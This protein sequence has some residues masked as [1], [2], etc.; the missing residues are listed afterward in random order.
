MND[1]AI[2]GIRHHGPGSARSVLKALAELR[3]D[4]I[5]V[6]G[7][8]D[9]QGVLPLAADPD[10]KPPVALLLYDPTEPR[11][12]VYYP[13]AE[14][15][16][17]WQAIRHGLQNDIPVRLMDLPQAI[18]LA[19]ESEAE[20]AA[21]PV[22][23]MDE[24]ATSESPAVTLAEENG[25]E[26]TENDTEDSTA[27][28]P[29]LHRDPLRWVAE[30]AGY[31]DGER[32]WE[33]LVE[34]RQDSREL[35]QAIR[36][37]MT[38]LRTEADAQSPSEEEE[39]RREAAMRVQLRVARKE[40]FERIA[41][42]CGAW[43]VPALCDL[44]PAREDNARLKGL[45]KR[46]LAATWV[47][48][49]HGRLT[50]A[51][52]YGAGVE[53]PGFYQHL[54][55]SAG[56]PTSRWLA[57]IAQ[58]L[59]QHD[60]IASTASV[61]EAARLAEALA[62]LRDRPRPTLEELNEAALAVLCHGEA[63]PLRLIEEQL[64]IG[65][66][67]GEVPDR[68]PM[69][70]LQQDMQRQQKRLRLPPEAGQRLLELDL[71]KPNDLERSQ[72]LHRLNLLDISWGKAERASGKG[73]FKEHWRLQ[74]Q[75]ELAV[76]VIEA[77]L[78]GNTVLDAATVRARDLAQRSEQLS[79]LTD[80]VEKT[81]LAELPDAISQVM[82]RLQNVAALTSDIPHLMDSLPAL[83]R[84]LRYGNVRQTDA[85][86]VGH[87]VDGL[88]TRVAIGLPAACGSLDDEAAE[89]MFDKLRV[90]NTAIGLLQ[91]PEQAA[92]W[93]DALAKLADQAG[94][95]GLLAG[96]A[97]RLLFEQEVLS[98]PE[99]ARR[100]GLALSPVGEP[101]QAAAWLEGFLHG[102]GLLLL[103]NEML[104]GILDAWVSSLPGEAFTQ[105]L[106]LLRR[107]FASFPA[108]ERRQIGERVKHGGAARTAIA[109][110]TE[111]DAARADRVLPVA[112]RLL[113]LV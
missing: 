59:R 111:V 38:A 46:K 103:H 72:L 109:A 78:W 43:H 44:P 52:G 100:M 41:V 40:G 71:R 31:G 35:F 11:R 88:I 67:L 50:H 113:G 85:G 24:A 21:E 107:T 108:P 27:A 76:A 110:E 53:A 34:Q 79:P 23:P 25:D 82:D 1:P 112:A 6:E 28:L 93:R 102:S 4:L 55:D 17:E 49:T 26:T 65:E 48:W 89:V 54:W 106:P 90:M 5:L 14:F 104:W 30:A 36:E 101:A 13:F 68:T 84:V 62:A 9:A 51:S 8:P 20:S 33:H 66:R 87:V 22:E 16:P 10:M 37:L 15:S 2:F 64:T 75:P 80:L 98:P 61:I 60:L 56:E 12:A 86:L 19:L 57:R 95:H 45:P 42:I 32:W 91:N 94:L 73:T 3:P 70:P 105:L 58:L 29:D 97:C 83:A 74:W 69:L 99:T 47:P 77:N 7:P 81:L 39:Q 63:A 92:I 96:Y 18:R